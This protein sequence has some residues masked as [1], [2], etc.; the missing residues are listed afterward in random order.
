MSI[1]PPDLFIKVRMVFIHSFIRRSS[2]T[3]L[4]ISF[5]HWPNNYG[6]VIVERTKGTVVLMWQHT[7]RWL[8]ISTAIYPIQ[9]CCQPWLLVH[10]PGLRIGIIDLVFGAQARLRRRLFAAGWLLANLQFFLEAFG[11]LARIVGLVFHGAT[12]PDLKQEFKLRRARTNQD[13]SSPNTI[14]FNHDA[15]PAQELLLQLPSPSESS[16]RSNLP[17]TSYDVDFISD[18]ELLC[19]HNDLYR[20]KPKP[21][22]GNKASLSHIKSV[23]LQLAL[24]V[25]STN[26]EG[27][28][29]YKP[30]FLH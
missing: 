22:G 6:N 8:S 7:S 24:K 3:F 27:R 17:M 23:R 25:F 26:L 15:R 1:R 12:G 29:K 5:A 14:L 18:K 28:K 13:P 20:D 2:I 16:T 19:W 4:K 30:S 11:H 21:I 9:A 10:N